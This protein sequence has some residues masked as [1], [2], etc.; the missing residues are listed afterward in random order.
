MTTRI[1][2]KRRSHQDKF[3][4]TKKTSSEPEPKQAHVAG[5]VHMLACIIQVP[6]NFSLFSPI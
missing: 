5:L 4:D 3:N 2:P 1:K 6:A